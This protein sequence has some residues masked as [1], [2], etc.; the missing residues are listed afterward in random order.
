[1]LAA[2]TLGIAAEQPRELT[3]VAFGDSTTAPRPTV[4]LVYADRLPALLQ[5]RGIDARV[6]NSGVGGSHT[7]RLADNGISRQRR[8]WPKGALRFGINMVL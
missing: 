2:A 7:G 4:E 5:G 8:G 1:L 6:V 3:I